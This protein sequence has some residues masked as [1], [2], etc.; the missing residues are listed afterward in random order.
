MVPWGRFHTAKL[1]RFPSLTTVCHP[2]VGLPS[3]AVVVVVAGS[4]AKVAVADVVV[5]NVVTVLVGGVVTVS[6]TV[7]FTPRSCSQHWCTV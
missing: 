4:A 6:V 2:S 3:A 1:G 5:A 7:V